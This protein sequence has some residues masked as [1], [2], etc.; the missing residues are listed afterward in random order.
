[1]RESKLIH[2]KPDSE[3][4]KLMLAEHEEYYKSLGIDFTSTYRELDNVQEWSEP[5]TPRKVFFEIFDKITIDP[6]WVYFDC[7]SGLGHTMYL[8]SFL[9]TRIY[10]VEYNPEI[11]NICE[12]NLKLL[13]PKEYKLF[14]CNVFDVS[15]FIFDEI[16]VLYLSSPF[17]DVTTFERLLNLIA[18][19]IKNKDREF[20]LV[21]FYPYC[22][23]IMAKYS[24]ILPLEF[25]FQSIGKVNYYHHKIETLYHSG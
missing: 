23:N 10:G 7:G 18:I 4:N 12:K 11:A 6:K 3:Y 13:M 16:N 17:N 24:K 2:I 21:Y 9:F 15:A 5:T 25:S 1:M 22:E 14:K 20:W 19:S 8:A